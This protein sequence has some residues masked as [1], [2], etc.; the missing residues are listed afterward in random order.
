MPYPVNYG[1]RS[2]QRTAPKAHHHPPEENY[3]DPIVIPGAASAGLPRQQTLIMP[4]PTIPRNKSVFMHDDEEDTLEQI[5]RE[6]RKLNCE[7]G[8]NESLLQRCKR[9]FKIVRPTMIASTVVMVALLITW[10][11]SSVKLM[12]SIGKMN[13]LLKV[14]QAQNVMVNLSV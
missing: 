7:S 2:K 1:S 11:Y 12:R 14:I 5:M 10:I 4:H 13:N 9:F 8:D 6:L 3:S